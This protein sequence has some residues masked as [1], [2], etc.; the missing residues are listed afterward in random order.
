MQ[1]DNLNILYFGG[2]TMKDE[3]KRKKEENG[4][5]KSKLSGFFADLKTYRKRIKTPIKKA[6]DAEPLIA[7][8][9]KYMIVSFVFGMV[10]L[11]I[12]TLLEDAVEALG[13]AFAVMGLALWFLGFYFTFKRGNLIIAVKRLRN[14]TCDKCGASLA[15][16]DYVTYEEI[17]HKW[18]RSENSS[19]LKVE[20]RFRC[21]CPKCGAVK[22]FTE[23]LRSGE[24]SASSSHLVSTKELVKDYLAGYV[25]L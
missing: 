9:K 3:E 13:I 8:S 20:I 1:Q 7:E 25:R 24:V 21:V 18:I 17:S 5:A 19:T 6:E 22:T 14:L 12:G 2:I 10:L 16:E 4:G 23:T 11:V 15:D